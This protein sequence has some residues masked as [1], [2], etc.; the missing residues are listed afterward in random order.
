MLTAARLRVLREQLWR[1]MRSR[2]VPCPLCASKRRGAVLYRIPNV[3]RAV[4]RSIFA[5]TVEACGEC[6]FVYTN[7]RL[8]VRDLRRYYTSTY[9]LE[10]LP[11]PKSLGEFFSPRYEEMW[12][13]KSRDLDL[14]LRAKRGGRLLDV[15]CA[16]GTLLWLAREKGFAVTGVEIARGAA[17]FA[18]SV[19]A[20]DVFIG[21]LE[22]AN[23]PDRRFDVVTMFHSLEHLPEP[24]RTLREAGR[25]LRDDG[26]LIVVVPNLAGWSAAREGARWRWLQPQNHYSHFTPD[27]LARMA[28]LERF[29]V[30]ISTEEGRYGEQEIR[31]AF[32]EAD[33]PKIHAELRGS[34]IV[35]FGYKQNGTA[36]DVASATERPGFPTAPS[37]LQLTP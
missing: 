30:T 16:S 10:G 26:V 3:Q 9:Q 32:A 15:G 7:P 35:L 24:R 4:F 1:K 22:E 27:T 29:H 11:V 18:R 28:A 8:P 13:S 6:G 34:E 37:K 25:V 36:S 33:I 19:L 20:L 17:E 12:F 14:V 21:Q 23:F 31:A 5:E 2:R